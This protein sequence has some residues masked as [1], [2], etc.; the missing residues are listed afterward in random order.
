MPRF[1][2]IRI[3]S[4]ESIDA[5]IA[6]AVFAALYSSATYSQH[7]SLA[8]NAFVSAVHW[9]IVLLLAT[10][11]FKPTAVLQCDVE[12]TWLMYGVL[13]GQVELDAAPAFL[14]IV[15]SAYGFQMHKR[16]QRQGQGEREADGLA[17]D[18]TSPT[19][20]QDFA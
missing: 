5:A 12:V 4:I 19:T 10:A 3:H 6:L 11:K 8:N 15:L 16:K 20:V 7:G 9:T 2:D 17:T 14:A 13:F 1:S 18:T